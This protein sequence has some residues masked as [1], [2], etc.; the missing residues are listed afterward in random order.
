MPEYKNK[1]ETAL[2]NAQQDYIR[3]VATAANIAPE[4]EIYRLLCKIVALFRSFARGTHLLGH[5][6]RTTPS[7]CRGVRRCK[8]NSVCDE[9]AGEIGLFFLFSPFMQLWL[10][11]SLVFG[12]FLFMFIMLFGDM[13]FFRGTLVYSLHLAL[14]KR[15][16]R[17]LSF[18][19][20]KIFP[21]WLL[22][23]C[24]KFKNYCLFQKNP[25]VQVS[26]D[27]EAHFCSA[28]G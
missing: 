7:R 16:P 11:T 15:I 8:L 26:S 6:C 27:I 25:F 22:S 12:F 24:S 13:K 1:A 21:K 2:S 23:G 28:C 17:L 5:Y 14:T 19:G 10:F 4:L 18:L 9:P 3:I 20:S